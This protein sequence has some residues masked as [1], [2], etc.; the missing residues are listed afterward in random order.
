MDIE[1]IDLNKAD[2]HIHTIASDGEMTAEEIIDA[3]ARL[4]LKNISIT[5]HDGVGA[6]KYGAGKLIDRARSKGVD[7]ITGTELDSEYMGVEVHILGY[8]IDVEHPVLKAHLKE[9]HPL[10]I[11]RIREIVKKVNA[12]FGEGFLKDEEIFPA[13]R[14]TLM[15]PHVVRELLSKGKFDK[16]RDAAKWI[17]EKCRSETI[18]P[19]FSPEKIISVI[20]RSGGVPVLAHPAYYSGVNGVDLDEMIFEF[21]GMGLSGVEVHYDYHGLSPALFNMKD[22]SDICSFIGNITNKYG[23]F[24]TRGSDSHTMTELLDRNPPE[25]IG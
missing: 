25:I 20:L 24:S 6:Y 7:F 21:S 23:L 22:G 2:L 11:K 13:G 16:Y 9:I 12:H 10:R 3:S 5:D 8:G 19:K 4:G 17:S 1:K 14:E 15:K 18:V